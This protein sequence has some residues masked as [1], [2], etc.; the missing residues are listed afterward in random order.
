LRRAL[1]AEEAED[2]LMAEVA[3]EREEMAKKGVFATEE[4]IDAAI[5]WGRE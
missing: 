3:A 4:S 2:K 1:E 5:K